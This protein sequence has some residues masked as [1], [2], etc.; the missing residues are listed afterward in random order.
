LRLALFVQVTA[1]EVKKAKRRNRSADFTDGP[2]QFLSAFIRAIGGSRF[3]GLCAFWRVKRFAVISVHSRSITFDN[4]FRK[5]E[6]TK[7]GGRTR[8]L[9]NKAA[10]DKAGVEKKRLAVDSNYP[11]FGN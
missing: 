8:R 11:E 6:N 5:R 10:K 4:F 7:G 9:N 2:R 1:E 3:G